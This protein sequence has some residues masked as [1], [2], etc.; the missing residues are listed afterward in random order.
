M[1]EADGYYAVIFTSRQSANTAGYDQAARRMEELAAAQPGFL[2][3]DSLRDA[4]GK[5][6]TV[7][8]WESLESIRAWKN[9]VEHLQAQRLGRRRWYAEY[10]L[11][12]CRVEYE[13]RHS[14]EGDSR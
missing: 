8:Y 12:V 4:S 14:R 7:S 9:E 5:G 10:H 3:I 6:I 11:R 13:Y 2:G 1:S